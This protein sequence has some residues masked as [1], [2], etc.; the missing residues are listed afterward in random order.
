MMNKN[1]KLTLLAIFFAHGF[2]CAQIDIPAASP[3]GSVYSK[4]GLTDVT[5]DYFRPKVKGRKIFGEGSKD[6]FLQ[7]YDVLWRTGAN[8]GSVLTLGTDAKIAGVNVAGGKYLILSIPGKNEWTFI[9][10]NDLGIGGNMNAFKEE[11]A[12]LTTKV[13]RQILFDPVE[14]LTFQISDLSEDNTAAN[15]HFAW[16]DA[17]FKVPVEVS[18]VD[19]VME[20]I[21]KA[22]KGDVNPKSYMQA[23]K[24]YLEQGKDLD[25]ALEW[26]DLYLAEGNNGNQ[27]WNLYIKAK[28]LAK[29]GRKKEAKAAAKNSIKKAEENPGGDFGYIKRNKDLINSLK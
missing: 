4:V 13:K 14:A 5:I 1:T 17:S 2:A 24:F 7:P 3:P 8:S 16:A 11:N 20:Q 26:A 9:L 23:A 6:E 18:Y 10:Y 28:I 25:Q 21:E 12:V 15:I 19:E 22:T 27:F 29:M